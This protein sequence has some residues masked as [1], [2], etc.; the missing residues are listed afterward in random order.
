MEFNDWSTHMLAT[1][2]AIKQMNDMLLH[3]KYEKIEA[4]AKQAKD[5]IDKAV[6]W[7]AI[8]GSPLGVDILPILK[9][10]AE[11][12]GASDPMKPFAIAAIKEIEQLR[13]ERAFWTGT[14]L[15]KS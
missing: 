8:Q 2:N 9:N 5:S 11:H 4:V 15:K 10:M 6:A 12:G 3:K 7:V 13:K 14:V 1:E